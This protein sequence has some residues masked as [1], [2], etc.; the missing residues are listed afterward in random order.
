MNQSFLCWLSNMSSKLNLWYA[1]NEELW[2]YFSF[3]FMN[4]ILWTLLA[5]H[6]KWS[7]TSLVGNATYY[8]LRNYIHLSPRATL[9][10]ILMDIFKTCSVGQACIFHIH[11][12]F[13]VCVLFVACS[14]FIVLCLLYLISLDLKGMIFNVICSKAF[15]KWN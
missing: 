5:V 12:T 11:R 13:F 15:S 4:F 14:L 6:F 9:W 8:L 3:L 1:V 10:I 2:Q 7:L